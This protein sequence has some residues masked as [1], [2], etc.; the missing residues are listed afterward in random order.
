MNN[1]VFDKIENLKNHANLARKVL[2]ITDDKVPEDYA[3]TV[4]KQCE[5]AYMS[6]FHSGEN[7]K[8]AGTYLW[9]LTEC[10]RLELTRDDLIIAVG[11]GVV[12]DVA[13]FVASTYMRGIDFVSVP[14]SLL[15]QVDASVGG[16]TAINLNGIKNVVGTFYPASTVLIDTNVLGT[17]PER[18]IANGL[19]ESIKMAA[20]LDA[21]FFSF[22]EN[23]DITTNL[24]YIV[25]RSVELKENIVKQDERE[26][27]LR[28][29]LNF[30]H[31]VGH[32]IEMAEGGKLLHGECVALGMLYMCSPSMRERLIGIYKKV[33][34]PYEYEADREKL[35][36]FIAHDKKS[37]ENG[38]YVVKCNN[39]GEYEITV[40]QANEVI[41]S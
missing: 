33:G 16:K 14:T 36:P 31:T 20:C 12:C 23:E 30:G 11:G 4:G 17:L 10:T 19:A 29:V 24:D 34:L 40:E 22:L 9:L 2:V 38:I 27:G 35:L 3:R 6:A 26:K 41:C 13:G 7:F 18:H 28:R 1:I 5:L 15:A 8:E 32:A 25:K 37:T 21:E 39:A